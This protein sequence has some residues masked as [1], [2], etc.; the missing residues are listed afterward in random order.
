M[1]L[2]NKLTTSEICRVGDSRF[3]AR[4]GEETLRLTRTGKPKSPL[5]SHGP[6][7]CASRDRAPPHLPPPSGESDVPRA[8]EHRVLKAPCAT[9]AIFELHLR[10]LPPMSARNR[11]GLTQDSILPQKNYASCGSSCRCPRSVSPHPATAPALDR[12]RC[13]PQDRVP[14]ST[15]TERWERLLPDTPV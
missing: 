9:P 12:Q 4:I 13:A 8:D 15:I 2:Y 14:L 6:G 3:G 11:T 1:R 7:R 10:S 5:P